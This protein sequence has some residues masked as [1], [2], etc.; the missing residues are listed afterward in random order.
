MGQKR[1]SSRDQ[2]WQGRNKQCCAREKALLLELRD[3]ARVRRAL[4]IPVEFP[5]QIRR[6]RD[7]ENQK[8]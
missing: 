2:R 7:P 6:S 4:G 5:V 8:P 3:D 1:H